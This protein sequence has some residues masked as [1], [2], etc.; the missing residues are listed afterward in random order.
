MAPIPM[1]GFSHVGSHVQEVY[2]LHETVYYC[3]APPID[4]LF[5]GAIVCLCIACRTG[6]VSMRPWGTYAKMELRWHIDS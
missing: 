1:L 6:P 5:E 4:L 3:M 2:I